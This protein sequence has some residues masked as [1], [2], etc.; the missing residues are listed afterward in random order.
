M[1]SEAI[2]YNADQEAKRN[3]LLRR[4]TKEVRVEGIDFP[5]V[6]QKL[7]AGDWRRIQESVITPDMSDEQ[8]G[9]MAMAHVLPACVV[10]PPLTADDVDLLDTGVLIEL[11]QHIMEWSGVSGDG[12]V[13]KAARKSDVGERGSE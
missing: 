7:K 6:V 5:I 10:D 11:A 4:A 9:V 2:V 3:A 1:S 8:A 13:A 12:G